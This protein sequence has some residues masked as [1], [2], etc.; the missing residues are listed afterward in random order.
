MAEHHAA[1]AGHAHADETHH[2]IPVR[3]YWMVF[4]ALMLGLILTVLA[5]TQDF[6]ALN[7]AIAVGIAVGKATLIILYFM[8]VRFSSRLVQFLAAGAYF[9]LL[10][11][12]VLTGMDYASRLRPVSMTTIRAPAGMSHQPVATPGQPP[13]QH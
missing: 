11:L 9:W 1:H 2:V 6:G 10:I 13:A 8:H 3:V 12:F 5:A 4:G 7:V